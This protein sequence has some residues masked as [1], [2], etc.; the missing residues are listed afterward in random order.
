[1]LDVDPILKM[2]PMSS[3]VRY[4]DERHSSLTHSI[5][6]NYLSNTYSILMD[7]Y[8]LPT[9]SRCRFTYV[10]SVPRTTAHNAARIP[11][12][13]IVCSQLLYM[14][15]DNTRMG[16]LSDWQGLLEPLARLLSIGK[17]T[18][19]SEHRSTR[20]SRSGI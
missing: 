19:V 6:F 7:V 1:M 15:P 20:K 13:I 4:L 18:I 12:T 2:T 9:Y 16:K 8:H 11:D 10:V 14:L 17:V 5:S 3:Q